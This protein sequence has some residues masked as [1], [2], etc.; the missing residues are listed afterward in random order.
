[1]AKK[2]ISSEE[3]LIE[4]SEIGDGNLNLIFKITLKTKTIC[5]KQALPYVRCVGP[6]WKLTRLRNKYEVE[7]ALVYIKICKQFLPEVY[8]HDPARSL[9]IMEF[10]DLPYTILRKSL[11]N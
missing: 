4:F 6:E 1:M 11:I 7:S 8:L 5:L 10:L 2:L 9:F 3:E